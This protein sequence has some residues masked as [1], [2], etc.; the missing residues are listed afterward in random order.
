M[1][2]PLLTL[3]TPPAG[4]EQAGQVFD[5]LSNSAN[6]MT[7]GMSGI[8]S[9]LGNAPAFFKMIFDGM[10]QELQMV[11]TIGAS[12]VVLAGIINALRGRK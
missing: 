8:K 3:A 12:A 6:Q 10:P 9:M 5:G 4:G 2:L 7:S 11:I 1:L